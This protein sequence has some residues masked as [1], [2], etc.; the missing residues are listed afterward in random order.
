M[1]PTKLVRMRH[2]F[3]F[4]VI[5]SDTAILDININTAK[6]SKNS[7]NLFKLY[8]AVKELKSSKT[9]HAN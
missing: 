3:F 4:I 6:V 9:V 8:E 2:M 5:K 1:A 7:L